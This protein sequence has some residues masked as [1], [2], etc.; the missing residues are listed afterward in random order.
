MF[1]QHGLQKVFGFL[2][3]RELPELFTQGWIGGYIELIAGLLIM[4]G[5]RTRW[6]AFIASGTMA[7]A[8]I[9]FHWKLE[10]GDQFFPVV[11]RGELA[12][13]YC[14]LFLFIATR[15]GVRWCL[16]NK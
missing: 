7:V 13:L 9:Q 3:D 6:A 2:T 12:A 5:L 4:V 8:Y 1:A 15:G 11:N 10:L 14:F 16:D